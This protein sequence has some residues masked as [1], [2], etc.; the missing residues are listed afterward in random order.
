MRYNPKDG[1]FGASTATNPH[2]LVFLEWTDRAMG[3][4][5]EFEVGPSGIQKT[6]GSFW[7]IRDEGLA[8]VLGRAREILLRKGVLRRRWCVRINTHDYPTADGDGSLKFQTVSEMG[9]GAELF[10]DWVFGGWWHMGMNEWDPFVRDL[11]EAESEPASDRR[12]YW[13]G[14]HLGVHQRALYTE[15]C[16][17]HP[18]K[19]AGGFMNWGPNGTHNNFTPMR[20]QCK[21]AVLVDLAGVGYSGRLKMLAF[22]GRPLIVAGRRW[23]SWA[24]QEILAQGLH[25][26]VKEDLSDLVERYDDI[27]SDMEGARKRAKELKEFC[28]SRMTFEQ[29]CARAAALLE[30]EIGKRAKIL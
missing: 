6:R 1:P 13:K 24:D 9:K 17:S 2:A 10:P 26:D 4:F 21:H 5:V 15:L 29:A 20:E 19:F 7:V 12:A 27:K 16:S 30:F 8:K 3:N 11:A 25:F 23:W 18:D 28:L 22:T 14:A